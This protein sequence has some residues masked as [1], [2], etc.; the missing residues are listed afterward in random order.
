MKKMRYLLP[1]LLLTGCY[2]YDAV[3]SGLVVSV[4]KVPGPICDEVLIYLQSGQSGVRY[5]RVA[6]TQEFVPL[7][8]KRITITSYGPAYRFCSPRV[9][10]VQI[11]LR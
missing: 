6:D 7:I 1:L 2:Q 9:T 11:E 8:G 5:L 4:V 10:N 3:S